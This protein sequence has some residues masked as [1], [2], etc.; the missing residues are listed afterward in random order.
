MDSLRVRLKRSTD[1]QEKLL[2]QIRTRQ[3]IIEQTQNEIDEIEISL[4]I[5]RN[6]HQFLY[7][8]ICKEEQ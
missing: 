5:E 6:T 8:K 2:E 3:E 4:M 1:N 7:E